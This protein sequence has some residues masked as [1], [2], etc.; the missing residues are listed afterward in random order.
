[1]EINQAPDVA[2]GRTGLSHDSNQGRPIVLKGE[3]M[4]IFFLIP[5]VLVRVQ[6][7]TRRPFW[8]SLFDPGIESTALSLPSLS[9]PT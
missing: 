5:E 2:A 4:G 1:M 9:S 3:T 7:V 6:L 8:S